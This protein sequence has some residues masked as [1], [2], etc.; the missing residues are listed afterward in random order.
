M[1]LI[2]V[3]SKRVCWSLLD[4]CQTVYL[5]VTTAKESNSSQDYP[6]VWV[7]CRSIN[8]NTAFKILWIH[9]VPVALMLKQICIFFFTAP[10]LLIK[11]AP[12][13]AQL[14]ILIV[15]WQILMIR[16]WLIPLFGKASLD[17]S[18]NTLLLNATMNHINEQIWRK[19][20]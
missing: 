4:Q 1:L 18:A 14:M 11:D 7:T 8:S 12:S 9:F 2:L 13:W 10:C 3:F 19:S 5:I 6:L 15:L 17:T 20:F 16:Y